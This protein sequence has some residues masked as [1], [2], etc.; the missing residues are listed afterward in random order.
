MES[1]KGEISIKFTDS[2]IAKFYF[3]SLQPETQKNLSDRS[4]VTLRQE[5]TTLR[6]FIDAKDITAFRATLNSFLLWAKVLD[7]V[8]ALVES[9]S[10][11]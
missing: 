8:E 11:P 9:R 2:K 7:S 5:D 10:S 4:K 1:I 6:L 3:S